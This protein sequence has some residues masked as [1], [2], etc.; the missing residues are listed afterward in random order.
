[1]QIDFSVDGRPPRKSQ[2]GKEDAPLVVELREAALN[3]RKKSGGKECYNGPVKLNLTVYA[4]NIIDVNKKTYTND[5]PNKF[6]GDLDSFVSGV[7]E[8]LHKGPKKGENDFEP[9]PLFDDKPEIDPDIP[10]IIYDDSQIVEINARKEQ[11]D[12]IRYHVEVIS[13]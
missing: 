4:P 3:A 8:Y 7:C 2:W 6:I 5:D 13:I 10:L 9:H 1:M 11:D 12:I